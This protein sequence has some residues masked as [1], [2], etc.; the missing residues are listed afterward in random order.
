MRASR[1]GGCSCSTGLSRKQHAPWSFAGRPQ[2]G[3]ACEHHSALVRGERNGTIAL[4][5]C[6]V[7]MIEYSER[8]YS[9]RI[10]FHGYCIYSVSLRVTDTSSQ[11]TCRI[12]PHS[13]YILLF[14]LPERTGCPSTTLSSM[15][16][17]SESCSPESLDRGESG[18]IASA[19]C[20]SEEFGASRTA[21]A[22]RGVENGSER[23][24]VENASS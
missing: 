6:R 8:M 15:K 24:R 4:G 7:D 16:S 18:R 1:R 12:C 21:D 9:K 13:S 11:H 14:P 19:A 23:M 17:P 20:A 22:V 10:K 5:S 2:Y 3:R